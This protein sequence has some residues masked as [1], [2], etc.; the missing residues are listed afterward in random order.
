[1]MVIITPRAIPVNTFGSGKNTDTTYEFYNPSAVSRQ[2]A[3]GQLMNTGPI[4]RQVTGKFDLWRTRRWRSG[5]K[6]DTIRTLQSIHH[7]S[8]GYQPSTT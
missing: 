5:F 7:C 1:M 4:F 6:S 2:L 3:F 8:V